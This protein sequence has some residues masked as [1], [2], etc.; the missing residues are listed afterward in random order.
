[1]NKNVS[2]DLLRS[3]HYVFSSFDTI[4]RNIEKLG[5][6]DQYLEYSS[7]RRT[8]QLQ[9]LYCWQRKNE[10]A[11]SK[12]ISFHFVFKSQSKCKEK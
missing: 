2:P 5:I 6:V 4:P 1:M 3:N 12:Q 8:Y 9:L 11:L 10:I 7:R